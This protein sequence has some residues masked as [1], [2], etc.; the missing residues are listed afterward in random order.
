MTLVRQSTGRHWPIIGWRLGRVS[1]RPKEIGPGLGTW[2]LSPQRN[3]ALPL[4]LK[5]A[6]AN[7]CL[8]ACRGWL[9]LPRARRSGFDQSCGH[10]ALALSLEI[11]W[12]AASR[13]FW[14][15]ACGVGTWNPAPSPLGLG[16]KPQRLG[17]TRWPRSARHNSRFDC[18]SLPEPAM[19]GT[20]G[21]SDPY[22]VTLW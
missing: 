14:G 5:R 4:M 22:S 1:G 3:V 18:R 12:P 19:E 7:L 20:P 9:R 17:T 11:A 2:P 13:R 6:E 10:D 16:V 21:G 8:D 15:S